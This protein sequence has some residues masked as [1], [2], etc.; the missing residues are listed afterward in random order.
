MDIYETALRLLMER[1]HMEVYSRHHGQIKNI[2]ITIFADSRKNNKNKDADITLQQA[3]KKAL[4]Y[5]T[6][7]LNFTNYTESIVFVDSEDSTGIQLV[8]HCAGL[9]GKAYEQGKKEYLNSIKNA[10]RKNH[11]NNVKGYGVKLI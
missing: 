7:F 4:F 2:P 5:G 10:I 11:F 8:D 6:K 1:F 3:Y 9:F